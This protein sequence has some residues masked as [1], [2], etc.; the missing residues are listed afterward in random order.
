MNDMNDAVKEYGKA[1]YELSRDE[2]RTDSYL[3]EALFVRDILTKEKDWV[4]VLSSPAIPTSDRVAMLDEAFGSR[5]D[6][7]FCSFLKLTVE[8]GRGAELA[9]CLSE[10]IRL[11]DEEHGIETAVAVSAVPLTEQQKA[12]LS[13]RMQKHTGKT[14]RFTYEVDPG[15]IGGLRVTVDGTRYEGSVKGRLERLRADI[16]GAGIKEGR[17]H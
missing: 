8:H 6:G 13:D 4:T 16:S 3:E 10:F 17:D 15:L 9:D 12:A 1:L 11:Y 2:G 5:T 7:Y 14:L